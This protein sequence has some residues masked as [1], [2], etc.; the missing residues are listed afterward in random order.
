MRPPRAV[1]TALDSSLLR[2]VEYSTTQTLDLEF[3][4]GATYRYFDVPQPVVEALITADS[5]GAYFN[6]NIRTRFPYQRL[7]PHTSASGRRSRPCARAGFENWGAARC[8]W[9][10]SRVVQAWAGAAITRPCVPAS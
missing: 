8:G 9:L 4:S 7:A 5:K 6:R 2:S 3:H 10:M 1:R